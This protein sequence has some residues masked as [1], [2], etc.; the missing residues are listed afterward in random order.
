MLTLGALAFAAPWMLT[1]LAILPLL[2]WLLKVT[3]PTPRRI[4]FPPVRILMELRRREET[5]HK[6]PPWLLLLRLA[7]ASLMVLALAKPLLNP[8]TNLAGSGPLLIIVDDGWTAARNWQARGRLLGD[9][10]GA[11]ERE[12]RPV[13]ILTTAPAAEGGAHPPGPMSAEAARAAIGALA[14]KPWP[15]DRRTAIEA[16]EQ[17]DLSPPVETVWLSDGIDDGWAMPLA[18]RLERL[19]SLLLFRD[20]AHKLARALLPPV[21]EGPVL[22]VRALRAGA[23]GGARLALRASAEHGRV[24]AQAELAFAEGQRDSEVVLELPVELRN[25]LVRLEI[26]NEGSAGAVVLLDERWRRR[27]VGLVSG[28]PPETA[29]PLLSDLYYLER[30]L[31]PFSEVRSGDLAELLRRELSVLV[32]ADIGQVVGP[33]RTALE[34]WLARGGVLVRFAGPRLA[35]KT[36]ELVPVALRTGGRT[37]GGAMSWARPAR[38]APFPD[39]S[40]FAGLAVPDDVRVGRQVLAEPELDLTAKSWASLSDGTPLVTAEHRGQGWLVLFHTT[41]N[42]TWTNLP[43]SGLFVD[44]L[45]RIVQL[46]Q[47]VSGELGEGA[48]NPLSTLD[49]FGRPGSPPPH[50]RPIPGADFA[51]LRVGPDHPPGFYGVEEAR[52]ALNATSGLEELR[53]IAELPPGTI[54]RDFAERGEIDLL[55]WLLTAALLLGLLDLLVS[56]GLRGLLALRLGSGTALVALGLLALEAPPAA[57][58]AADDAAILAA[59]LETRLA[60]V[61]TGEAETDAMS[62]A[63]LVGLSRILTRRTSVEP[64]P[65]KG[66]DLETDEIVFFPMLYWPIVARQRELSEH[67]LAKL[68]RYMKYGGTIVFDT[69]DQ[70]GAV[71]F[72]PTR[73]GPGTRRLR[74][75]LRALDIPPLTPVPRDHVLT[76]SY[77]LIQEFPGRWAGGQ[78]WVERHAGGVNDGVSSVVIGGNDW[79]RAWALDED[80]RPLAAV[81]PGGMVQREAAFR[82]GVNLVMY[83]LTGN[84]KADQVHVPAILERLGQ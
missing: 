76:K 43:L 80:G 79:A 75:I 59:V 33:Q 4:R 52:R 49:A 70:E 82:F 50:V 63:G 37:L 78:V 27:P 3:P 51:D 58:Q 66:V 83:V 74:R 26:E 48:L 31:S 72:G 42:T 18:R 10:V 21:A 35:E 22:R 64:G 20:P 8:G 29:Q 5:P 9:L 19:G 57:A 6:T 60:Y 2:W 40:P 73:I 1:A 17:L 13:V 15:V 36:D 71:L 56:L 65:P 38:L 32:L 30:A 84:Y 12:S 46:G 16:L 53:P 47:G 24:L 28:G 39:H 25:R 54:A 34:E 44:M 14:P 45:R 11:A 81:V 62:R 55:P 61:M 67:A 7:L 77:Y 68:D 41:A 69:R 23:A